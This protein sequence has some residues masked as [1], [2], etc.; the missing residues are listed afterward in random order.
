[1][2]EVVGGGSRCRWRCLEE[3]L[4]L[5]EVSPGGQKILTLD[6]GRQTGGQE[7]KRVAPDVG[8]GCGEARWGGKTFPHPMWGGKLG[9]T[10]VE[11]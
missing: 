9:A 3:V 7:G 5:E 11:R 2:L 8:W 10:E 4:G 1:M 6:V